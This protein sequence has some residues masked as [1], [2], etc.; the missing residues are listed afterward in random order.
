M[1]WT[2]PKKGSESTLR[3]IWDPKV[4]FVH[5][6]LRYLKNF[7][8]INDV[9]FDVYLH[10]WLFV[11]NKEQ[12]GLSLDQITDDMFL[13]WSWILEKTCFWGKTSHM[14][15]ILNVWA[16]THQY[17]ISNIFWHMSFQQYWFNIH[18]EYSLHFFYSTNIHREYSMNITCVIVLTHVISQIFIKYVRWI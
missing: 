11:F 9:D 1:F 15:W 12:A 18:D 6:F 13:E 4:V 17:H 2:H 8:K 3:V 14:R 16:N 10:A 7:T 5:S